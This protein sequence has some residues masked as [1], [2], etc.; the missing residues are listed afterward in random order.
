MKFCSQD[1]ARHADPPPAG[2]LPQDER[3]VRTAAA[4]GAKGTKKSI[5]FKQLNSNFIQK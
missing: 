1:D 3:Q 4:G 5:K 2:R